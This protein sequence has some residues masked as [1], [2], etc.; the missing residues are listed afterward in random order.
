MSFFQKLN[1]RG[2]VS[3]TLFF[4]L[5]VLIVTSIMMFSQRYNAVVAMFH[6]IVGFAL[7][8]TVLFHLKNNVIA[9][10]RYLLLPLGQKSQSTII[11]LSMAGILCSLLFTLIAFRVEPLVSFYTWSQTLKTQHE[12]NETELSYRVIDKTDQA[13]GKNI[14][15]DVRKGV[16]YLWPQYAIWLETMDGEFI[17]PLLIT[18]AVAKRKFVNRVVRKDEDLVF[19]VNPLTQAGYKREDVFSI[20]TSEQIAAQQ[21]RPESLPV[22]LHKYRQFKEHTEVQEAI[23]DQGIDGYTGAT[24]LSSFLLK[25]ELGADSNGRYKVRLEINQSFDFNEFYS[26]DRF[27]NDPIYS[28]NGYSA[29]PSLIYEAAVDLSNKQNI[30]GMTLIGRGHH[31]GRDGDIYTD[32]NGITTALDIVDRV[33]VAVAIADG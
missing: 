11:T 21:F 6:I 16:S 19:T 33:I 30:Y 29:Q 28:G 5:L 14:E 10:A 23:A 3:L 32:L 20:E 26:S 27:P 24:S 17:R 2:F 15:V 7:I 18:D 31:S 12:G 22:F 4:F 13:V 9:L 25:S 8:A 1:L